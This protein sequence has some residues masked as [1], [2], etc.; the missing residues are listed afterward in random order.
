MI[1]EFEVTEEGVAQVAEEE[2]IQIIESLFASALVTI[3]SVLPYV[4]PFLRH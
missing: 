2:S 1:I 3:E 4:M